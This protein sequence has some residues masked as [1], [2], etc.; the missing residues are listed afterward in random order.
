MLQTIRD[1]TQGWIA[2]VIVSIIILTFALWGIHSYFI[3][4]GNNDVVAEV[5]GVEITRE[6]QSLAYER[7][8]RQMQSMS[9][10]VAAKQDVSAL[11]ERALKNLIE[12]ETL[13][14][15]AY[16]QG[17]RI[18]EQQIDSYLQSM[19]ELQVDGQF[20]L[21]RLQQ[22]LANAFLSVSEFLELM[23]TSLLI[24]QPRIG[25]L[26]TATAL[27]DESEYVISLVNQ[28]RDISYISLPLP[29]FL[30]QPITISA[31][32]IKQYYDQHQQDFLT[33]EQVNVEYLQL[34]L[35]DL[36]AAIT[37]TE[38]EL[39]AYYHDNENTFNKQPFNTVQDKVKTAYQ[40]QQAQEKFAM[41][42]EQLANIT[43]EHPDSLQF[44]ATQLKLPIQT[45][46]MFS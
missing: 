25:V 27:P 16:K 32:Q 3:G 40:Q 39:Q 7:L 44:A 36:M 29:Y 1:H 21:E 33:T 10:A 5:N 41:L 2:G 18:S 31:E 14:Q 46:K 8:Q 24:N 6:Q 42:R 22:M 35:K 26:F 11:K 23:K 4:G 45:S 43:Y 34:S 28:E 19:P 37:P 38:V 20:S 9:N 12:I 15:A 30:A 17:F 13:K